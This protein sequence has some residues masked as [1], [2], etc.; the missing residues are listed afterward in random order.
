MAM[1]ADDL[2]DR[3]RLRRK[4]T[5]W[6]VAAFVVLA[7]ALIAFSAWVYDDE[8]AGQAVNHI[9]RVK[10]EGT[11]TEDD[12]LIKRLEAIR[13]SSTVK[14][15]ILS[16]D[17]PGGTTVGGESIYEEVRKLAGEKPVVAEVG[18]LAASAGYMIASAAD[19]IVARK[20]SIVG[21]IG[22]LIQYPDVSGL[23][24]KLGIKLEEVKSSPLKASPS[25][26]KPTNDEERAMVRKLILDSYDWFVGIVAE[27]R[28]MTRE[29]AL[30]LADGSIFTGRQA[31]AN[32]LV[33]A[34]GGE[35]E[36][37]NWLASKGVDAKLKVIEWKDKDRRGSFLFSESMAKT[38]A[39]ALGLPDAGG[40]LI[41]ELGADRM[42][43]DGLVSVWH[44]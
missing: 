37:V 16:I 43:L 33:D 34:V 9:A 29:Q 13:Q 20:T 5:F 25:P 28:K 35:T 38:M 22:V 10:I 32:H 7:A 42:F 15:V 31:L 6:R 30:A 8:F 2:I 36:A 14:G 24:D 3:R 40:D 11:I 21:S 19:H 39:R 12:E 44:P 4:L 17:S 26:F 27:R 1:R 23:M 41:H 18:T